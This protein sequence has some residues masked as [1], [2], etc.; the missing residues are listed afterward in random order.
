MEFEIN[1]NEIMILGKPKIWNEL[2]NIKQ[3]TILLDGEINKRKWKE[4]CVQDFLEEIKILAKEKKKIKNEMIKIEK[5]EIL[6]KGNEEKNEE[7]TQEEFE[8]VG[9]EKPENQIEKAYEINVG[10]DDEE[11]EEEVT[12]TTITK[13][14]KYKL[15]SSKKK[16][17]EYKIEEVN[18]IL[19]E[20]KSKPDYEEEIQEELIIEGE[21]KP[22][23]EEQLQEEFEIVGIEKPENEE[24]TQE[25]FEKYGM[26]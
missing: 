8:I 24:Q 11:E 10:D 17:S 7:Q 21:S 25:E 12:V 23:N 6:K 16:K 5:F 2:K 13:E 18:D 26:N 19:I 1:K 4:T 9:I 3:E 20:S 14:T 22:E 15:R